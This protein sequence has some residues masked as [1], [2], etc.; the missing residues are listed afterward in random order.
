MRGPG[1]GGDDQGTVGARERG[2]ERLDGAPI[3]LADFHEFR[4]VVDEGGVENTVRSGCSAAQAFQILKIASVHLRTRSDERLGARVRAG[5]TEHLMT[6]VGQLPRNGR[7][8][9]ARGT[10]DKHTH[11]Q[12]LQILLK[13]SLETHLG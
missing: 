4:E 10:G 1:S 6:C 13:V 8:Y 5:E 9:K 3:D 7:T 12:S 11:Q 2:A